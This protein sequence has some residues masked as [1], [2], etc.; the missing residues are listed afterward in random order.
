MQNFDKQAKVHDLEKQIDQL[1][2]K[3]YNLTPEKIA[4]VEGRSSNG[5]KTRQAADKQLKAIE[6]LPG[7]I[8]RRCL[9]LKRIGRA[10]YVL[11]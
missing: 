11:F 2:Y 6:S 7:A 10:E 4:I 9:I 8:L 5:N 1:V 3:L